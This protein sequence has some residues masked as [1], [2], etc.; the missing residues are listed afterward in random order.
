[1]AVTDV[2]DA[3]HANIAHLPAGLAA[4]YATG[5]GVVPWTAADWELHPGAVRIDQDPLATDPAA[6]V[7]DVETGAATPAECPGW[8]IRALASYH[9]ATRPGQ[10]SPAIYVSRS[11]V[12]GVVNALIA[13]GVKAG[14][15]LWVA[16]WNM[17]RAEAAADVTTASGPFPVI[18]IQY[19]NMGSYDA[20]VFSATWL[21]GV[22]AAHPQ[23]PAQPPKPAAPPGQWADP[24]AWT[25]KEAVVSGTGV[26]GKLHLFT[27][28]GDAWV[29]VR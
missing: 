24:A 12:T 2:Y 23:Q 22:S 28:E 21:E 11:L 7:L 9:A 27:L 14:V 20:S 16:D 5:T 10:R 29:K 17:N 13:G 6:D 3:I 1:M 8:A 19:A 25:W 26:D 4:G 18:G 15:G